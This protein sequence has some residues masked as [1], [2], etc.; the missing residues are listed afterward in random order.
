MKAIVIG[1][2]HLGNNENDTNYIDY[3][4]KSLQWIIDIVKEHNDSKVIFL[5]D[6]FHNRSHVSHKTINTFNK[7]INNIKCGIFIVGN[8]DCHFK[9]TNEL[10]LPSLLINDN[11]IVV[12]DDIYELDNCDFVPWIN[13]NNKERLLNGIKQSNCKYCFGH[14]ELANFKMNEQVNSVHGQFNVDILNKY[15]LVVSGHYHSY[16]KKQNIMYLG[17]PYQMNF[18]DAN[19]NKHIMILD[20]DTGN[21][22]LL[23]NPY[24]YFIELNINDTLPDVDLNNHNIKININNERTLELEQW[25]NTLEE[26][27]NSIKVQDNYLITCSDSNQLKE[28]IKGLD[29]LEV[30]K[31]YI[32]LQEQSSLLS[33]ADKIFMEEYQCLRS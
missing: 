1:D 20:L 25:L 15:D 2:L 18:S 3:Q 16:S 13:D 23:N 4:N 26:K 11:H 8:H 24:Q 22:E 14:F 5:G 9:N 30:W 31:E 28:N 29:I 17:T 10:N 33:L 27:G 6:L 12:E 7:F 32:S 21:Y 19:I